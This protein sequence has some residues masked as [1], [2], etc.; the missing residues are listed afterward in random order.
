MSSLPLEGVRVVDLSTAYSA[1]I[2][3]MQLA[4]FG[5]EVIK[6]ENPNMGDPSRTWNPL[7]N[8]QS[9]QFLNMNRNK[10]SIT[11]NLKS[12]EGKKILFDLVRTADVVVENFRP[13][14][15][16]KLGIDYEAM[17]AAKPDIIMA[18][19]SGYGQTGPNAKRG[20]YSNLAEAASG[21]MYITGYPDGKPTGSGA[22][23]GD[24]IAGM[25]LVQG[26]LYALFYHEKT[27]KG[28]YIDVAM[29]DSLFHLIMQGV[30]QY[31]LMGKEAERI[32]CRDLSAYPYDLFEAA[33]GYCILANSTVNDW[34]PFAE[35]I[36]RADLLTDPRFDTNEHR[37]Q[38]ADALYDIIN[39][40]SRTRTR[41]EIG[42]IFDDY[43]Q[44]FA[45]V[46]KISEAMQDEQFLAR[47]MVVDMQ[48]EGMGAYKMQGIPVKMSE[49]PGQVRAGCPHKGEHTRQY[50]HELGYS[51]AQIDELQKN[52]VI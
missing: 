4:D 17:K 35:A 47:D 22:A 12:E 18:S 52:H 43:H 13:G 49:T 51:E 14:V 27:G 29:T 32:G 33:D 48:Y 50:L 3:T 19:L 30:I 1:P 26:I 39:A 23:F 24:S 41:A 37:V 16:K 31:S 10:K 11:L 46:R 8:G 45:P 40:W 36:G 25:F 21:L 9:I 28:Q 5:A 7:V 6:I 2:G 20:A 42:K 34:S 15:T 44:A 38:N